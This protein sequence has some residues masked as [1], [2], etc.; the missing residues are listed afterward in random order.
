MK[1][2]RSQLASPVDRATSALEAYD[3]V[4]GGGSGLDDDG[5]VLAA[6]GP[7]VVVEI[8]RAHV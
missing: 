3:A 6:E 5:E 4:H 1:L 2:D 7:D 8:G